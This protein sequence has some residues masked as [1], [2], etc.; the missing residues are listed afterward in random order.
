MP[1]R[2]DDGLFGYMQ[3]TSGGFYIEMRD[4]DDPDT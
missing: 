3:V 1:I 4:A 2:I